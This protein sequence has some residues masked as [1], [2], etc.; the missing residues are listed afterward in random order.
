[1]ACIDFDPED[2]IGEVSTAT[3]E[4]ELTR[5]RKKEGASDV[6]EPWAPRGFAQ[7]IRAVF[8]VR[9][10]SRFEFLLTVLE[11]HEATAA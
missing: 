1:M 6:V 7:D 11:R 10:A 3:L 9:D 4:R 5:R 2:Y 8:Y